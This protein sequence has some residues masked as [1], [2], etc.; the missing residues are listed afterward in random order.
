M[1]H[2]VL[3]R[4]SRRCSPIHSRDPRVKILAAL[5]VLIAIATTPA[6]ALPVAAG[7]AVYLL[8]AAALA[9]LP[10]GALL[11]RAAVVLPF[12]GTF[13]IVSVL[14][15]D[16]GRAVALLVKSYLSAVAVLVLVGTTPLPR[17]LHGIESL[18]APRMIVLIIQFLYRYLFVI[19]EQG[20]HMR[21]SAQCRGKLG[22]GGAGGR[23]VRRSR[24][25]AAAGA[26]AVLFGR[27]CQ[28]AEAIHR[29]MLARGFEGRMRPL[30]QPAAGAADAVFLLIAIAAP[31]ALR[32][33]A[34]VAG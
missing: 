5:A 11:L 13:A 32:L 18:G 15:G 19:S 9:R 34:G 21:Q 3:D 10:A 29:A 23:T 30:S 1:H 20:Q 17:L 7:Y 4:W 26:L 14:A 2:V 12:S 6:A 28:R 8:G 33:A 27:S 25:R 24:Y 22:R 16:P 31:V